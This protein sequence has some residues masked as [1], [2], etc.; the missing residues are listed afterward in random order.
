MSLGRSELRLLES[1][2]AAALAWPVVHQLR[3]HL[4]RQAF[5]DAWQ[6]QR[7]EGVLSV[8]L[9]LDEVCIGYAGYRL[10]HMLAHGRLLYVDD[11]VVDASRRGEG[12]GSLLFDWLVEAARSAGCASLQLDSG[13]QRLGAHAFYFA[14]GMAISSF[15][16]RLPLEA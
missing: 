2:D 4:D 11:L 7:A 3:P 1:P 16:F 15:H 12:A 8:G 9:F 14:R 6:L 13:T 5:A 10:Q